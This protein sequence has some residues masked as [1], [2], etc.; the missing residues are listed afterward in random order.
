M[1]PT[2]ETNNI[3]NTLAHFIVNL[4]YTKKLFTMFIFNIIYPLKRSE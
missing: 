2:I 3:N 4:F 1:K